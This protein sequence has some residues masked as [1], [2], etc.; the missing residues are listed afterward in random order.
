MLAYFPL[1]D[2][3]RFI[4]ACLVMFFHYF[5]KS[6]PAN[7]EW[8]LYPVAYG[9]LG[10]ELFFIIS[11]FVIYFSLQK[12]IKEYGLGR[13]LRLYP[14]F[15]V[16]ATVTYFLTFLFK[17]GNPL[18]FSHYLLNMLLIQS[19]N[20]TTMIDGSYWTLTIEAFFY[21]LIGVFVWLFSTKYL[22]AFYAG[23]MASAFLVFHLG[24]QDLF[25]TKA[26]LILYVPYFVFGGML[27]LTIEKWPH[28][29][30]YQKIRHLSLLVIAALMPLYI[31]TTLRGTHFAIVNGF[32]VFDTSTLLLV[33]SFFLIVPLAV[34]FS[35]KIQKG[36]LTQIAIVLG[37]VTYPLYLL[38][39]K[40]GSMIIG[41]FDVYGV[42]SITS[43]LVALGMIVASYIVYRIEEPLRKRLFK[44]ILTLDLFKK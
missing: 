4:A 11:G 8:Y 16:L 12:P 42:V 3:L 9:H 39:Q 2:V 32:G 1:I 36:I 30:S 33:E 44:K 13:F 22:E 20:F 40:I 28:S 24:L 21:I 6:I 37:G 27:G 29:D 18:S 38:H 23:W 19:G 26:L 17:D 15:W 10:V 41:T 31:S 34:Y 14:L 25:F 35:F 5:S 7:P 43:F